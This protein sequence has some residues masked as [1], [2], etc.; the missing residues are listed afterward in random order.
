[1]SHLVPDAKRDAVGRALLA[2]FG[3]TE[4]DSVTPITGGLSGAGLFRIRVGGIAYV[5]RIEPPPH[6]FGDPVRGHVCM[7]TAAEA[8]LAPRVRYAD[9]ADGVAIMELIK[10]RSI[11]HDYPGDGLPL[12]TELAQ[13]VRVLHATPAFPP[14]VDYLDGMDMLIGQQRAAPFVDP[15]ALEPAFA[16]FAALRRVYRT[17]AEDL[18]SSHND[19]NPNNILYDGQRLWLID[20]ETAFLADRFVDLASVANWFGGDDGRDERLLVTYFGG[21]PSPEQRARFHLMRQVNHLFYGLIFLAGAAAER[22]GHLPADR[23]LAGPDLGPLRQRL[24]TGDLGLM[25]WD[26]R[27]TYAKARLAAA[28]E[29]LRG[30]AFDTALASLAA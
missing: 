25:A 10:T 15:A 7:R 22:P 24:S 17:R 4:L 26:D 21:A 29:G 2:A 23:S 5:L 28:T 20:W 3:T 19:L 11:A 13:A 12:I 18:V 14:L 30:P 9:P 16:G 8:F 27:V 1:M 6:A